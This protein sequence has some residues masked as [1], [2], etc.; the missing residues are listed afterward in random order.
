M[1]GYQPQEL[2]GHLAT[3]FADQDNQQRMLSQWEQRKTGVSAPYELTWRKKDGGE[4]ITLV[5][6]VPL[7]ENGERYTGSFAVVTDITEQVL[8]GRTLEQRVDER[9]RELSALLGISRDISA[10]GDL[11][12]VLNR[13]LERLKTVVD[14]HGFAILAEEQGKWRILAQDCPFLSTEP[15]PIELSSSE[16]QAI[17]DDFVQGGPILIQDS[18]LDKANV[19]GFGALASRLS[20]GCIPNIHCWLGV[21]LFEKGS[22]FGALVLG[23]ERTGASEDQVKII[24]ASANQ[25]AIAIENNR[26]HRQIRESV[27][28]E[29]RSRLARDL[30]D[31]VTQVLFS[32]SLLAEVLPQIW[33]RN[34]ELGFQK[35]DKLRQLTRG[36]LAEMRTMLLELRPSAVINT[37]LGDLLAQLAAAATSRS[38]LSFQLFIEQIPPLPENV[39]INFYRIAQEALNNIVK[40][41]QADQVT[42]SLSASPFPPDET[43]GAR[44][45]VKLVIQDNGVGYSSKDRESEGMGISIMRERA[46]AIQASLSLESQPG[47]G[48]QVTLIWCGETGS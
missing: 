12:A 29:E 16:A 13:I 41:A 30:H 1:L 27:M 25:V 3:E 2:I 44:Q 47:H 48:T 8:A 26:L 32:A 4:V 39:Q 46:A 7:F 22:I 11:T 35:L 34:P 23:C 15:D 45:E 36:A 9:T 37:P 19:V 24:L 20:R 6:P 31:S 5:S 28:S 43:G 40:H 33:R 10:S 18:D 17:A 21:P 38:G 42:M 14:Y